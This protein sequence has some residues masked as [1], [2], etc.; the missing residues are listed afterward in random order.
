[1]RRGIAIAMVIFGLATVLTG[2][3]ALFFLISRGEIFPPHI[4][5]SA[6]FVIFAAIHVGLNRKPLFRYFKRLRWWWILV[7]LGFIAI[8]W[9]GIVMPILFIGG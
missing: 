9:T 3:W 6:L 8:L 5:S 2:G 4:T 7:G 1:M